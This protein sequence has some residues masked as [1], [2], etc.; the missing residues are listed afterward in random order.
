LAN[1]SGFAPKYALARVMQ[2]ETEVDEMKEISDNIQMGVVHIQKQVVTKSGRVITVHEERLQDMTQ[3]RHMQIDTRK[4]RASKIAWRNY[5]DRIGSR[6]IDQDD[7]KDSTTTIVVV[8]GLPDDDHY[9]SP[10]EMAAQY[11]DDPENMPPQPG[12]EPPTE[13]EA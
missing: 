3:H 7:D 13:P 4:W 2:L 12:A 1:R 6:P 11:A 10:E 5:G 9:V 8:N